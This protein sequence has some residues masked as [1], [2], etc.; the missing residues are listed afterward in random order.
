MGSAAVAP[1][2]NVCFGSE[3]DGLDIV[4]GVIELSAH[5]HG[6]LDDLRLVEMAV[7]WQRA[8][9]DVLGQRCAACDH[10]PKLVR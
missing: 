10:V 4:S 8:F 9:R 2:Q 5:S 1:E 6:K 3:A 7:G